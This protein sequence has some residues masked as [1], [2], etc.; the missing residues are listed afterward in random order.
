VRAVHE[1]VVQLYVIEPAG[2]PGVELLADRLM[3]RVGSA[4]GR[5]DAR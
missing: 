5:L 1:Q 3:G 2:A 4:T